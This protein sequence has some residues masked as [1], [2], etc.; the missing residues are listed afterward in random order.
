MVDTH[1]PLL[2]PGASPALGKTGC[3]RA[4][5][6]VMMTAAPAVLLTLRAVPTVAVT[7]DAGMAAEYKWNHL[8]QGQFL[9]SFFTGYISSQVRFDA[10]K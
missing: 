3:V 7:G 2:A 4:A 1:A 5:I 8:Q 6:V 9:S 10:K